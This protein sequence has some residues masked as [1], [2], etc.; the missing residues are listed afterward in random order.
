MGVVWQHCNVVLGTEGDQ[1][2]F[3]FPEEEVVAGLDALEACEAQCVSPAVR[4]RELV[5]PPIRGADVACSS[6]A[7]DVLQRS[8]RLVNRSL[9]VVAMQL[10][11]V[12]VL[13]LKPFQRGIDRIKYVP[14]G[15][16]A[17]P[18]TCSR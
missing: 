4:A 10:I 15:V 12:D 9:R 14:S 11:E 16:S 1:L 3:D 5:S 13:R 18:G 6:R 17:M 2:T 8:E 7:H